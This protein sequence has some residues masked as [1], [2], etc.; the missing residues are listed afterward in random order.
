MENNTTLGQRI[1]SERKKAGLSQRQLGDKLA[2]SDKTISKWEND[3]SLPDVSSIAALA[4]VFGCSV[5]YLMTGKEDATDDAPPAPPAPAKKK[6]WWIPVVVVVALVFITFAVLVGVYLTKIAERFQGIY[7]NVNN[8]N[9][10]YIV[11]NTTYNHYYVSD[12]GETT[13]LD[14]GSWFGV[15]DEISLGEGATISTAGGSATLMSTGANFERV[16]ASNGQK[17]NIDV[18]FVHGDSQTKYTVKRG[19]TVP[20]PTPPTKEG[21][22]FAGWVSL[23]EVS[24]AKS[25]YHDKDIQW[26]S[27]RY[28]STFT[29]VHIFDN[30]YRCVDAV[31]LRCGE[32][33]EASI[34]HVYADSHTCH[35]RT[36]LKCGHVDPATTEHTL[37]YGNRTEPT[38]TEDGLAQA[39]CT[40][41]GLVVNTVLPAK[42]HTVVVD[43]AVPATCTASG[44]TEGSHCATCGATIVKQVYLDILGHETTD[45]WVVDEDA[46]CEEGDP[47]DNPDAGIGHRHKVCTRCGEIAVEEDIP[48]KEHTPE[49]ISATEPT[50]TEYGKSEGSRCSVCGKILEAPVNT[51]P[52][53]GHSYEDDVC[54]RCGKEWQGKD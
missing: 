21:Y 14:S 11:N 12:S 15:G 16:S 35:D 37:L 29:C 46:T 32:V 26:K 25:Y 49:V 24:G 2:V 53:L 30:D 18:L 28:Q 44:W 38:C 17:D 8:N 43:R 22:A 27:V 48:R 47:R 3:G 7:I 50:C 4:E 42:G 20:S 23:D 13:L 34:S 45:E 36:C 31:C 41:C 39:H 19:S 54:T 5:V 10:Y 1:L 6:R 52:P 33:R 40:G 51:D 9:E